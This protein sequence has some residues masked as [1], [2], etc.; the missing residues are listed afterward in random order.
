MV[1]F[2]EKSTLSLGNSG[3]GPKVVTGYCFH[4]NYIV[5]NMKE[6]NAGKCYLKVISVDGNGLM[7]SV[8][9]LDYTPP[10]PVEVTGGIV[11]DGTY[12]YH[13]IAYPDPAGNRRTIISS[14]SGGV[15]TTLS[16]TTAAFAYHGQMAIGPGYLFSGGTDSSPAYNWGKVVAIPL[17][18]SEYTT[19][20][21]CTRVRSE[22]VNGFPLFFFN[23]RICGARYYDSS[24]H[25]CP[26]SLPFDYEYG[27]DYRKFG[28]DDYEFTS[29]ELEKMLLVN[30]NWCLYNSSIYT[31][32]YGY[33]SLV[34]EYDPPLPDGSPYFTPEN[35][36]TI[37]STSGLHYYEA[38]GEYIKFGVYEPTKEFFYYFKLGNYEFFINNDIIS[39]EYHI[40]CGNFY[41]YR[42]FT[43]GLYG[44]PTAGNNPLTTSFINL[45]T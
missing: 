20:F 6:P 19:S 38:V 28:D 37:C 15:P 11:S 24:G 32:L 40:K 44:R 13:C 2:T 12:L 1:D 33:N 5:L 41:Y 31:Y 35:I 10:V 22:L 34:H 30:K 16:Y 14:M 3:S 26:L 8:S 18:N 42:D 45:T 36:L 17:Y 27:F 43:P 7:T 39:G 4:D 9:D 25:Y 21:V 23:R 29:S